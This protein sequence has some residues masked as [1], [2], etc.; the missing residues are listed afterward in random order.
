MHQINLIF[1]KHVSYK[2]LSCIK[3]NCSVSLNKSFPY[4]KFDNKTKKNVFSLSTLQ[5]ST[6]MPC[7][8]ALNR[9]RNKKKS[10][11]NKHTAMYTH[12]TCCTVFSPLQCICLFTLLKRKRNCS[13]Y[14]SVD[15]CCRTTATLLTFKKNL[16]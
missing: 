5:R 9:L 13:S 8:V 2:T 14:I 12:V 3:W 10:V 11:I 6:K 7:A 16:N 15:L 1:T 4:L